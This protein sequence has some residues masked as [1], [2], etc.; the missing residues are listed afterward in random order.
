MIDAVAIA[1]LALFDDQM[2]QQR[3]RLPCVHRVKQGV[4]N[5]VPIGSP[6]RFPAMSIMLV[7]RAVF[8]KRQLKGDNLEWSK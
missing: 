4:K 8:G 7:L 1:L 6:F 3:E 5:A 2:F